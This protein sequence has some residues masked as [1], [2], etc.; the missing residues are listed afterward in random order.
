MAT[1]ADIGA[2]EG[3]FTRAL[4]ELL[5][6]HSRIYAVDRDSR[7]VAGLQRIG[8][9]RA[10]NVIP[11]TA[12]FTRPFELPGLDQGLDGILLANALH[13]VRNPDVVLARL[14]ARVRP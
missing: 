4:V 3:T 2:G 9:R 6:P 12:D 11:V 10:V 8:E 1:W 5:E 14:A 7:A 13:F